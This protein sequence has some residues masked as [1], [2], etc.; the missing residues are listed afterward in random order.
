M[1]HGSD[2]AKLS[3]RHGVVNVLEY[4]Q[5]C[6]LPEALLNYL[7]RLGWSPVDQ[8]IFAID[9]MIAL[10]HLT[11]VSRS[12]ANFDAQRL[13]WVNQQ[14]LMKADSVRLAGLLDRRATRGDQAAH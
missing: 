3:K 10:F 7:P 1:I 11:S 14:H 12:A 13:M 5:T 9:E 6:F 2:G 8:E 4:R